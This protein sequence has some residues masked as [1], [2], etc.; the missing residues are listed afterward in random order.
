MYAC[1]Q[2]GWCSAVYSPKEMLVRMTTAGRSSTV[3]SLAQR[4]C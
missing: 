2:D 3:K 4:N 1:G